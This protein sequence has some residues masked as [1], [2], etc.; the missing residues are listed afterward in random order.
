MRKALS[1]G[2][3]LHDGENDKNKRQGREKD[4]TTKNFYK[5]E[6]VGDNTAGCFGNCYWVSVD[7]VYCFQR[8][9]H[10]IRKKSFKYFD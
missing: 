5:N 6:I 9:Y 2:L 8:Y 7:I 10:G 3:I 1:S 4:E